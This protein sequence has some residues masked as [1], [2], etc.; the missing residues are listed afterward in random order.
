MK[1]IRN[2]NRKI[3]IKRTGSAPEID[4]EGNKATPPNTKEM[5]EVHRPAQRIYNG[6][7]MVKMLRTKSSCRRADS[8]SSTS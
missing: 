4:I 1:K 5:V 8:I 3:M 7:S 2:G 6:E